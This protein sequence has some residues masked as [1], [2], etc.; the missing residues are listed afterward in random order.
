[1]P[2]RVSSTYEANSKISNPTKRLN[3][4]PARKAFETPADKIS[5]VGWK[6]ETGVSRRR[7]SMSWTIEKMSTVNVT[8]VDTSSI[9]ALSRSAT[10]AM[11]SGSGH[12]PTHSTRVPSRSVR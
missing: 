7:S 1:M 5:R 2:P 8:I 11:P 10:S 9:S 6:I 3:R 4:S 12:A